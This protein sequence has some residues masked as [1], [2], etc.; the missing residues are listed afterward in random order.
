MSNWIDSLPL[1][2]R[3][4]ITE[5]DI[6][7]SLA[8]FRDSFTATFGAVPSAPPDR[9]AF[10]DNVLISLGIAHRCFSSSAPFRSLH[11]TLILCTD[12]SRQSLSPVL[13]VFSTFSRTPPSP[14]LGGRT[15]PVTAQSSLFRSYSSF[16]RSTST[17][18]G[19]DLAPHS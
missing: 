2:L 6:V 18:P 12:Y 15:A 16:P 13:K 7:S 17:S 14:V 1:E 4:A 5:S 8:P 19:R 9:S 10:F 3:H 11:L